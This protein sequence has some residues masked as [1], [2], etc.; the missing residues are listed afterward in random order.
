VDLKKFTVKEPT[1]ISF[2]RN[3]GYSRKIGLAARKAIGQAGGE[4]ARK[5]RP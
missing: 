1:S 5:A 3:R 2:A 4:A